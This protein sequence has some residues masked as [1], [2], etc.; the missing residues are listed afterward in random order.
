MPQER[1]IQDM[2]DAIS[3]S[4]LSI[5]READLMNNAVVSERIEDI[6]D[7]ERKEDECEESFRR[8]QEYVQ[9]WSRNLAEVCTH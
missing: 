6:A 8:A 9:Q 4:Y 5:R 2:I 3:N 7:L 1:A